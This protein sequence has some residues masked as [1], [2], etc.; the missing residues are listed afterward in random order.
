MP[1]SIH[2]TVLAWGKGPAGGAG[3]RSSQAP[4]GQGLETLPLSAS[5]MPDRSGLPSAVL[6]AGAPRFGC[7]LG[8]L[9]TPA[10]GYFSHCAPRGAAIA[11]IATIT[12]FII[13][14]PDLFCF[15][16]SGPRLAGPAHKNLG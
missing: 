10:V 4:A 16:A 2:P 12:L 5:H 14:T 3:R 1:K 9:G 15:P 8:I 7:P 13:L 11:I 6:G